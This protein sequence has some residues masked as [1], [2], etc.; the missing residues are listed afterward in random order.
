MK[1]FLKPIYFDSLPEE[2]IGN[3]LRFRAVNTI[4]NLTAASQ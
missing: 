3:P 2:I 1:I 4:L